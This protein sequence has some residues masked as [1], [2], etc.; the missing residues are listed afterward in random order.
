MALDDFQEQFA[1]TL[2]R[3]DE[4]ERIGAELTR[5][6]E[7]RRRLEIESSELAAMQ[8]RLAEELDSLQNERLQLQKERGDLYRTAERQAL[9]FQ[10]QQEALAAERQRLEDERKRLIE[11][12]R[13]YME[14]LREE[15]QARR[16]ELSTAEMSLRNRELELESRLRILQDEERRLVGLGAQAT[17]LAEKARDELD[18]V[19][20]L[21]REAAREELRKE[22]FDSAM[23]DAA[24]DI[25]RLEERTK[26]EADV[27]AARILATAM[28]RIAPTVVTE[29]PVAVVQLPSED[30]KARIIGK[31]GRNIRTF[32]S[33]TGVQIKIDDSPDAVV[34]SSFDPIRRERARLCLEAL[35]ADG[36]IQPNRIETTYEQVCRQLDRDLAQAGEDAVL[37]F[38][39]SD[40]NKEIVKVLGTLKLRFSAGQNV[41]QHLRESARFARMLAEELQIDPTSATRAALLHDLGK[42]LSHAYEGPHASVGAKFARRYG[43]SEAVCH[44]IEAHHNQIEPK[45]VEAVLVQ[46]ADHLSGG[47]PGARVTGT[48][49]EYIRRIEDL[50]R[51][52]KRHKGVVDAY[53]FQGGRE[54]R[55]IIDAYSADDTRA[56]LLAKE[57]AKEIESEG[58]YPRYLTVTVIRELRASETLN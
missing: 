40:M 51:L 46:V 19:A 24:S 42:G 6:G 48:S 26:A 16:D 25:A 35:V 47:R 21:T 56:R 20:G 22:L 31:D 13:G 33:V 23:Q 28:Q 9:E 7:E 32:E 50:E 49:E 30:F 17:E 27:R 53:A 11:Q 44:A 43:E 34:L 38:G 10:R 5:I 52:C 45:T 36:R 18:R 29:I 2:Q 1:H 15:A 55:V 37:E 8:R 14:A 54:I 3:G 58:K 41:L 4:R 12:V 57:I 39:F